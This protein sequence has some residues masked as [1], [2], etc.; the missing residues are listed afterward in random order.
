MIA[1]QKA[2]DRGDG[3][4]ASRIVRAGQRNSSTCRTESVSF[5]LPIDDRYRL[6]GD[7]YAW[8]IE[9]RKGKCWRAIEWHPSIEAAVNSLGRRLVRTSQV[10]SL[11]DALAA[12]DRVACTLKD[13]LEPSF[14]REVRS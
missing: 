6:T 8:R 7:E 2:A 5:I 12:V 11:V 9:R 14:K 13:A 4:A 10:A 1:K 3:Q